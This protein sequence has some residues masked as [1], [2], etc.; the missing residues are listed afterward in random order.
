M[1]SASQE[2]LFSVELPESGVSLPFNLKP[3]KTYHMWRVVWW[4]HSKNP[5]AVWEQRTWSTFFGAKSNPNLLRKG[6]PTRRRVLSLSHCQ[7]LS[8]IQCVHRPSSPISD[9]D[10]VCRVSF[11]EGHQPLPLLSMEMLLTVDTNTSV[12][13]E[14]G[15]TYRELLSDKPPES[16]CYRC[17]KDCE[18]LGI[19]RDSLNSKKKKIQETETKKICIRANFW[20]RQIYSLFNSLNLHIAV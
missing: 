19:L 5:A 12:W 2:C 8:D 13:T 9:L 1:G 16:C 6:L 11:K 18:N 20:T 17:G 10:L 7:T 15:T 3:T 4:N 14:W